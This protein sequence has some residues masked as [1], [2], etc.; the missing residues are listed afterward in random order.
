MLVV[1]DS[2]IDC[3]GAA[4]GVT[5]ALAGAGV[6]VGVVQP[7]IDKIIAIATTAINNTA[8]CLLEIITTS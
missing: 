5:V 1:V 3:C 4:V 6:G 8:R 7:D 2:V